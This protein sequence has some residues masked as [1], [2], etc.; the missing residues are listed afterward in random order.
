MRKLICL[1]LL[2]FTLSANAQIIYQTPPQ[3]FIPKIEVSICFIKSGDKVLFLKRQSNK[4]EA[5]TWGVPGGKIDA[6]E[7]AKNAVIREV[8]EETGLKLNAKT[9]HYFGK[10]YAKG[11]SN[12]FVLHLFEASVKDPSA[13]TINPTEHQNYTWVSLKDSLKLPLIPGEKECIAIL[14]G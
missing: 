14:Y 7:T 4:P 11:E 5:N 12:D 1:F 3:N 2:L 6:G 9:V 10:V 13:V 8:S